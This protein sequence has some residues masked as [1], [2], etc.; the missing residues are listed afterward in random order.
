MTRRRCRL[1]AT[2][3]MLRSALATRPSR[4]ITLPVSSGATLSSTT[5]VRP[6]SRCRT[7]T[8]SGSSTSERAM[9]STSGFMEDYSLL[10]ADLADLAAA[11]RA[12]VFSA[13]FAAA[14]DFVARLAATGAL[15]A[16][17]EPFEP[18]FE[19]L[20]P[21]DLVAVRPRRPASARA[22]AA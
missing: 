17:L 18:P 12:A 4:P 19:P 3:R 5:V 21:A 8:A 9:Y 2:R 10:L 6:A 20:L 16:D 13:D 7:S 1:P 15:A 11:L 22:P 14:V